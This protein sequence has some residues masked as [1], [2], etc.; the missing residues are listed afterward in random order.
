VSNY[1]FFGELVDSISL[2]EIKSIKVRRT[3]NSI[4]ILKKSASCHQELIFGDG[5][6]GSIGLQYLFESIYG[7]LFD[8]VAGELNI[9]KRLVFVSFELCSK[10]LNVSGVDT[11][12]P[13]FEQFKRF[14]VG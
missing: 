5:I 4:I 3:L 11:I 13:Y 10:V 14:A 1:I 2:V 9:K 6:F 8:F 7:F 12:V